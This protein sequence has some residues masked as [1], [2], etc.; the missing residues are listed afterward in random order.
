MT[1][2]LK[3]KFFNT[4]L[5]GYYDEECLSTQSNQQYGM[6]SSRSK[7]S[8]Y[9]KMGDMSK[10]TKYMKPSGLGSKVLSEMRENEILVLDDITE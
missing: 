7:S 9:R 10:S 2:P 1:S 5:Y 3:S 4:E 6:S 8:K